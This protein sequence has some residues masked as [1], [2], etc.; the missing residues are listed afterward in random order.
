MDPYPDEGMTPELEHSTFVS[1]DIFATEEEIALFLQMKSLKIL[2][3]S[4]KFCQQKLTRDID[5]YSLADC[6]RWAGNY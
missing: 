3:A 4:M 6:L 2:T 1:K 5:K